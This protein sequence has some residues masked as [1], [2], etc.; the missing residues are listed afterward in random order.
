M[1]PRR[2]VAAASLHPRDRPSPIWL[3][4]APSD[5]LLAGPARRRSQSKPLDRP[6]MHLA[7]FSS[8][9]FSCAVQPR[10]LGIKIDALAQMRSGKRWA[11]LDQE[12]DEGDAAR[13][14]KKRAA[15]CGES[16][17]DG[18]QGPLAAAIR[19]DP[20]QARVRGNLRTGSPRN[21]RR[22]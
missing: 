13:T 9:T 7:P 15:A 19:A 20:D 17:R 14:D 8:R 21:G 18:C 4:A 2:A 6:L 11:E 3:A 22:H 12:D 16:G 5:A 10:R 1:P